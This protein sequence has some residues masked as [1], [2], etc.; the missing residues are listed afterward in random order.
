MRIVT[1]YPCNMS[2]DTL[3]YE[4]ENEKVSDT[5]MCVTRIC[6]ITVQSN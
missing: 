6:H 2:T 5:L 3:L 1:L 4:R